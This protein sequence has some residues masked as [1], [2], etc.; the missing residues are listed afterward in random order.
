MSAPTKDLKSMQAAEPPNP[1]QLAGKVAAAVEL[2]S[3]AFKSFSA[4][5]LAAGVAPPRLEEAVKIG[6]KHFATFA[7]NREQKLLDVA[8]DFTLDGTGKDSGADIIRVHAVLL[9][10]YTM[11]EIPDVTETHFQFFAE[12]NGLVNSWP[13]LRE[14]VHSATSRMG[15]SPFVMEVF[16]AKGARRLLEKNAAMSG[17]LPTKKPAAHAHRSSAS[18]RT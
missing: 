7:L 15:L 10:R 6:Y 11:V 4:D 9:L 18:K 3:V 12:L 5:Y 1:I 16:S 14:A 2:V 17:A 13:F 8:I